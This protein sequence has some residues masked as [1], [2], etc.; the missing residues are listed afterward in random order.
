M[1]LFKLLALLVVLGFFIM[2]CGGGDDGGSSGGSG[3][4]VT[5]AVNNNNTV[6]ED[7]AATTNSSEIW[8]DAFDFDCTS[9]WRNRDGALGI[10]T[11]QG[12]GTC[13]ETFTGEAGEYQL[14]LKAVTEY[15]GNSPYELFI[16]DTQV[17]RG[18]YPLSNPLGCDCPDD[19]WR[20]ICP[21]LSK[22][23]DMGIHALKPGD[24]LKF[25]GNDVY[26]CGGHGAFTKWYGI[27]AIKK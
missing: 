2:S 8:L 18:E 13:T 1:K 24:T 10:E 16:N 27:S 11:Y 21:D 25:R 19:N 4:T 5:G 15:D 12:I 6:N 26:P 22:D 20:E 9:N 14:V 3:E 7:Q 23:I 17:A